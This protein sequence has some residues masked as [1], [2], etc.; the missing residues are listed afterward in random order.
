MRLRDKYIKLDNGE[1]E[2]DYTN[3]FYSH[4]GFYDNGYVRPDGIL[5][6]YKE[7]IDDSKVLHR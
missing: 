5:K 1:I 6:Y 7:A 2:D 4:F 3:H